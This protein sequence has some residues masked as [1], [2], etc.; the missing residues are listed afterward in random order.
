MLSETDFA[1]GV[2]DIV[3]EHMSRNKVPWKFRDESKLSI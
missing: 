1:A 2:N 3:R